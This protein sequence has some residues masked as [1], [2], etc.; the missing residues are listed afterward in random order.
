MKKYD[1]I[2]LD[3]GISA[4]PHKSG[5]QIDYYS[6]QGDTWKTVEDMTD[7]NGHGT[8]VLSIVSNSYVGSYAVFSVFK[9]NGQGN[10]ERVKSVLKYIDENIQCRYLQMSFGMRGYDAELEQL[11]RRL[12]EKNVIIIAAFDNNGAM[13]FP[14]AFDFVIGVSG[15]PF[16]KKADEMLVYPSGT[17]DV[18]AKSGM[19]ILK[20]S[21]PK[22]FNVGQGNSFAASY[23]SL[24][25]LRSE[26]TF[27]DK[28]SALTYLNSRY[29][30]VNDNNYCDLF[31]R[32]AAVFPL[33]KEMYNLLHYAGNCRLEIVDVYDIKYASQLG[34]TVTDFLSEHKF[35]VKNIEKCE[36]DAFDTMIIGHLRELSNLLGRNLKKEILDLCLQHKKNVYCYDAQL[37]D[38]YKDKFCANGLIIQSPDDYSDECMVGRLYQY[39]TPI[40]GVFGTSKKQGKFTLQMQL[41]RI[42]QANGVKLGHL[43]TE[44]NSLLLGCQEVLPLGYDAKSSKY[45]AETLIELINRRMHLLDKKNYDLILAGAQSGFYPYL[46]YNVNNINMTAQIFAYATYPDGVILSVNYTDPIDFIE[47]TVNAIEG[48][49]GKKVFLFALYAFKMETDYIIN[50]SK[51]RLTE[52]EISQKTKQL[53]ERFGI[54]TV[55]SGDERYD[56]QI[57]SEI[58]KYFQ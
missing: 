43:G 38:E 58:C 48:I 40:I 50:S 30:H 13:S 12:Y 34:K 39:K 22:G 28:A 29:W 10:L 45:P 15:D 31:G 53:R 5:V 47:N 55:V 17:V 56:E 16:I 46:R 23:V 8:A 24:S 49:T 1:L 42:M 19:Q 54:E 3:S 57:F 25:L 33:N 7:F 32:K 9:S 41:H 52:E 44:P 37:L 27:K 20:S 21:E 14:A 6:Q 36:W 11:C 26:L 35:I 51:K 2:I 18:A 4:I